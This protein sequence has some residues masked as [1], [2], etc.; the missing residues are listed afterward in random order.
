MKQIG[1]IV[2]KHLLTGISYMIPLIVA[3][4]IC[5]ALGQIFGGVDVAEAEG[6]IPYYLNQIGGWGMQLVVP[7]IA[8]SIA[9]SIADRPGLAPGLV[10]GYIANEIESGFIGGIIG[11]FLVGYTVI[12]IKKYVKVPNS[13]AGLMPVMIIPVLATVISGLLMI[14]II[15]QPISALQNLLL[16]MLESMEGGSSF[17]MGSILG[18]MASFD[19]GGPVNKT[20]SLFAD[21]LLVDG[22]YGPQAVKFIGSMVPPFGI[23]LSFLITRYKYTKIEREALKAAVPMGICMITEGVIPIAARDIIRVVTACSLGSAVGGGLSMTLGVGSTVPHGG[24]LVVPLMINPFYFL[25]CL[26]IG[27]VITATILSVWKPAAKEDENEA[28]NDEETE[29]EETD[30]SGID[31][32]T[33]M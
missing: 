15:G 22:V 26:G 28:I 10:I 3:A 18:A 2:K 6:T 13:M 14:T 16:N 21:G 11:G 20:M 24:L 29:E 5:I 7:L 27:T 1:I 12:L 19:F 8:G 9:L 33:G 25:M 32:K 23:G 17:A 30:L 31:F 4:G